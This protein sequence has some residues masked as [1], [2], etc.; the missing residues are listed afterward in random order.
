ML[1]RCRGRCNNIKCVAEQST[2]YG[3]TGHAKS[4]VLMATSVQTVAHRTFPWLDRRLGVFEALFAEN[5]SSRYV[6]GGQEWD[7][8]FS[9]FSRREL[10]SL[11]AELSDGGWT[12]LKQ[13]YR[14]EIWGF[15]KLRTSWHAMRKEA[16]EEQGEKFEWKAEAEDVKK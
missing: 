5:K 1:Y 12:K 13:A 2:T 7:V 6:P 9:N 10:L 4:W 8:I 3:D 14:R 11:F 16:M 15:D